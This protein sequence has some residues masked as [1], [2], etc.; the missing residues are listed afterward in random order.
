MMTTNDDDG[1]API[2]DGVAV[3][4]AGVGVGVGGNVEHQPGEE[5]G[6][7]DDG[8]GVKAEEVRA[9]RFGDGG[10]HGMILVGGAVCHRIKGSLATGG[11]E[12]NYEI[13]ERENGGSQRVQRSA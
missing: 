1:A 7:G 6:N 4:G 8:K 2:G 10:G 13:P 9:F 11:R 3:K 5:D 12:V